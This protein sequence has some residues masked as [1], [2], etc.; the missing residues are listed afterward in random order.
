MADTPPPLSRQLCG[1]MEHHHKLLAESASYLQQSAQ[2]ENRALAYESG[3]RAPGHVGVVTIPV[4]VHVVH[5]PASPTHNISKAQIDSQIEVLNQDFRAT[6][7]DRVAVPSVW[8]HLIADSEIE[9]KLAT[10]DPD[11]NPTDGIVRVLE[12]RALRYRAERA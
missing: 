3:V 5:N 7:P 4:V 10:T 11:G 2:F 9:F 6:N 1:T 12:R 8:T